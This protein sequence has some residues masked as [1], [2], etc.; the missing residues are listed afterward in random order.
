[1]LSVL[2]R[3]FAHWKPHKHSKK[4]R[5]NSQLNLKKPIPLPPRH[6]F[7][8]FKKYTGNEILFA[9]KD[10][11]ELRATELS[12]ALLQLGVR[13][14]AP[15]NID[16]NVH[17]TVSIA[18]ET[19]KKRIPQ[20]PMKVLTSLALACSRLGI[21]DPQLWELLEK[22]IVRTMPSMEPIGIAYCFSSFVG[23]GTQ[24]FYQELLSKINIHVNYLNGRDLLNV[25][26]GCVHED[27][28][29]KE[30]FEKKLYPLILQKKKM[31]TPDQ[32]NEFIE[33]LGKRSDC[34]E[35][36]LQSLKE[37]R[38]YKLERRETLSFG[39]VLK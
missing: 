13:K 33:L 19:A 22:H 17:P 20:Y 31:C 39:G 23:K 11:Q 7:I 34:S 15:E 18:I 37:A 4:L 1:M 14:G 16:W 12:N 28:E 32:L 26:K 29:A 10:S 24:E 8:D 27:L 25:V 21:S 3:Q 2:L 38:E 9:L 5:Y 30:L 36:T 6:D 35:E